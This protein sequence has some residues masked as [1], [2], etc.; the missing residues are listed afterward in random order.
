MPYLIDGNNVMAR[1]AG[2]RRD[3]A[4]ARKG[5]VRDLVGFVAVHRV[6]LKVVFD[7]VP[8]D[9]FPDGCAFKGVR[10]LY[11]KLGSDADSRIKAIVASSS[12]KR[13]LVVVSSDRDVTSFAG[14]Q[15][16]KVLSAHKFRAM[17]EDS[18]QMHRSREKVR[19]LARE[20]VDA[21]LEYFREAEKVRGK[22]E[23]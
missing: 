22:Q 9:E 13:D 20:E 6:K 8:D 23:G 4:G 5:L 21:W 18:R 7:G 15:G 11:A 16:A 12:H 1:V 17:L 3:I 19:G 2:W 10:V 14:R